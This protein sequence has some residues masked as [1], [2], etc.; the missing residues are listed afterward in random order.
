MIEI[1]ISLIVSLLVTIIV[2]YVIYC[3]CGVFNTVGTGSEFHTFI[4]QCC[5][6]WT[7][8]LCIDVGAFI[9]IFVI[10]FV[11]LSKGGGGGF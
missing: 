11:L 10:V 2:S 3:L 9:I 8:I 6:T 4:Q 5:D 1:I 7:F